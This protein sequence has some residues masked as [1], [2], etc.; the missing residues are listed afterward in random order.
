MR[1]SR[2]I[3]L[4]CAA[5]F[6]VCCLASQGHARIISADDLYDAYEQFFLNTYS[7]WKEG[8]RIIVEKNAMYGNTDPIDIRTYYAKGNVVQELYLLGSDNLDGRYILF[9]KSAKFDGILPGLKNGMNKNEVTTLLGHPSSVKGSEW[10]YYNDDETTGD[11][12]ITIRIHFERSGHVDGVLFSNDNIYLDEIPYKLLDQLRKYDTNAPDVIYAGESSPQGSSA[13]NNTQD[14]PNYVPVS[15][16]GAPDTDWTEFETD[17]PSVHQIEDI[18]NLIGYGYRQGLFSDPSMKEAKLFEFTTLYG[19]DAVLR[20]FYLPDQTL[21]IVE[22]FEEGTRDI[23]DIQVLSYKTRGAAAFLGD[24]KPGITKEDAIKY[25]KGNYDHYNAESHALVYNNSTGGNWYQ[26]VVF[27]LT[28]DDIVSEIIVNYRT[29][30]LSTADEEAEKA[31]VYAVSENSSGNDAA[32][33]RP[34]EWSDRHIMIVV[35]AC[36]A[37]AVI[38]VLLFMLIKKRS[39]RSNDAPQESGGTSAGEDHAAVEHESTQTSASPTPSASASRCKV[40]GAELKPDAKFCPK[41]GTPAEPLQ[42]PAKVTCK[43]CGAE[44]KSG[45]K[46]CPKCGTPADMSPASAT[47]NHNADEQHEHHVHYRCPKCHHDVEADTTVC[48]GCGVH[49]RPHSSPDAHHKTVRYR[50]P[51]CHHELEAGATQCPGCGVRLKHSAPP[52]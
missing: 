3:A 37:F 25:M 51:K 32:G 27:K 8:R 17:Q 2:F 38:A 30:N 42:T 15:S 4:S 48:P 28:P 26:S 13:N 16:G 22:F 23:R 21:Q 10:Y 12:G 52:K 50:C 9:F 20:T 29:N 46:F 45:T 41:C 43:N 31:F 11:G 19:D 5:L 40:C 7:R 1:C 33:T 18:V 35:G 6:F 49:L 44:L 39:S 24:L 34:T 36:A 14:A 47:R